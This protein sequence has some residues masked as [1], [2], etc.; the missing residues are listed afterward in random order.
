[1]FWKLKINYEDEC[2]EQVEEEF[3][4]ENFEEAIA[5]VIPWYR[6]GIEIQNI[7]ID[8]RYFCNFKREV[9]LNQ[10]EE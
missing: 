8:R 6:E 10:K 4:F 3:F 9:V 1:M 7:S 2:C 5:S